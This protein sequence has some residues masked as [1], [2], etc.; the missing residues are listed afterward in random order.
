VK[1][2]CM[3]TPGPTMVP[4]EVLLAE[5]APMVHH[6][7]E[8]FSAFMAEA[9]EGL[10]KLFGTAEDV[11]IFAGS[12]TAGMEAAVAN[13]C[14]AGDKVIC[15]VGG[16]FGERW[17]ELGRAF[18]C[19]VVE[20]PVEWGKSFEPE[21]AEDVL[22]K[23]PDARALYITH[24]ETSTGALSDVEAIARLVRDTP[25]LLAV[26][27]ITGVGVHPV[28]MDEWGVDIVV[29]GSQ[30]GCMMA[31][32]LAFVAVSPRTWEAIMACQSPRYYLDLTAARRNWEKQGTVFTAPVSLIRALHKSLEMIFDEG[33]DRVH[34]RHARL[35]RAARAAVQALGLRL[36][37]EKPA[38]GVTA[39]YVPDGMNS[40]KL[41]ALMRD[42]HGVTIANGPGELKGKIIRIGHMGYVSEGDLLVGLAALEAGLQEL[43]Y[44]FEF[45]AGLCAAREALA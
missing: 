43:G 1:K 32:G 10:K 13:V 39:A 4:H 12:G 8:Q 28:K 20:V 42:K 33:L 26:D 16:K 29:S 30:K 21:Q 23:H 6:R 17:A 25:T 40:S 27:S 19:E 18:G 11:Y 22:H 2:N 36:L 31:P 14:S 35:G 44:A 15:A 34:E 3:L 24:S 9:V 37:A 5:A 7:T 45:G 41:I 38:N